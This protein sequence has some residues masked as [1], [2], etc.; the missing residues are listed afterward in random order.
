M[1]P[2]LSAFIFVLFLG[3]VVI[4]WR[5]PSVYA[6]QSV[7]TKVMR[8]ADKAQMLEV[9][10][11]GATD[12]Y[13]T[14]TFGPDNYDFDQTA[15][16]NPVLIDA[17]GN[18][19]DL[20]TFTPVSAQTGWGNL[21]VNQDH[22]GRK[23]RIAGETFE[24]GFFAHAP[25]ILHFRL[26]G[27]FDGESA[28]K[29]V[30]FRV[31]VG[32]LESAARGSSVFRVTSEPTKMPTSAEFKK[33]FQKPTPKFIVPPSSESKFEFNQE[34]AQ[35]LLDRGITELVFIRRL[36]LNSNHVYTDHV[37]SRWMPGGGLAVLD[38]RTGKVRDL[39]PELASGV[40]HRFDV[41]WDAKK[42]V[43]DF[44][45]D[46]LEG[47]RIYEI[48][49]DGT[50]L[51][52]LTFPPE[53]EQELITKYG[54]GGYHHGTDDMQPCYLPDGGIAFI[55][56]RC[57][58][59]VLCD[60]SDNFTV[61]NL[62]RMDADGGNMQPLTFSALSEQSPTVM[63][64]GRILY[65]RWEYL[66][67]AA[68]NVKALWAMNPDGTN[69]SEIYGNTI[70]FPE[71][72]IYA[73]QIPGAPDKIVF[74]GA[75]HCCPNNAVGTVI[76]LDTRKHIRAHEAM[77]YL[78]REVASFHHNGFHFLNEEGK[79]VHDMSGVPG[80]LFKD[81]Y[82]LS[83][84]LFLAARKPKGLPWNDVRGYD[85][86]LLDGEG[87]DTQL[88]KD[89][90]VSCWHPFPLIA[91]PI[92]PVRSSVREMTEN[93][94]N[95][96]AEKHAVAVITDIY[97]GMDDVPR[98]EVKYLRVLEQ[99]P[100][101]WSA[102]KPWYGKDHRGTTHAHSAIG[103]GHLSVKVQLGVIPV[104]EDGSAKFYVPAD[105]AVYFQALD[106]KY[107]AIQTERTYVNY[108]P[109]ETR[110]CVGC[111]ETPN[112]TP[113]RS[114][115]PLPTAMKLPVATLGHQPNQTEAE[116]V[117]DYDR[118]IQP[119]WDK[120]CIS[121]HGAEKQDGNL[122]LRGTPELT[123]CVSYHQLVRLS[124]DAKKQLLGNRAERNEDAAS[125]EIAYIPPYRTGALSST[126][127]GWL[128]GDGGALTAKEHIEY[129]EFLKKSHPNVK[130]S[131]TELLTINNWLDVNCP[132]HPSYF[133]H[134]NA[135]FA[136]YPNY[137]PVV[138][139]AEARQRNHNSVMVE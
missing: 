54:H 77:T 74:L 92:P 25:S 65:H 105:R 33:N 4:G 49:V 13:L 29:Y 122:D 26:S 42:I 62:Y 52:Q 56:T 45:P 82:P 83:E 71:C 137:R 46:A 84:T 129:V 134:L 130:L 30:K 57:E 86:V 70:A 114:F 43:F 113:T 37:N 106:E 111:H 85:L 87:N 14:A 128:S 3:L 88:L 121:C 2:T 91:R 38:L 44:K 96:E 127:S 11:D 22:V 8:V 51:R 79:W 59:S 120:H 16:C 24:R 95:K 136:D 109:G 125:N 39:A 126:L 101:S 53:N 7:E 55:S 81:P 97:V 69:S 123:Y 12:L 76:I 75:S 108:R 90:N 73:R 139:P 124:R 103:D 34:A 28:K 72:K 64:D 118:Q 135:E 99:I 21:V 41:S 89:V 100:R 6:F 10:L 23:F 61:T 35:K 18:E 138:T 117:F 116:M 110:A 48:N 93:T 131:E 15:W 112:D 66:D 63:A 67:K 40:V 17:D 78:T 132:Y 32:L 47:Y 80:R 104:A 60:A 119:I 133:G 20:T 98:G 50:G 36:T 5:I 27:K 58:I 115:G 31:H 102:R 94:E 1:K 68:G 107:R 19:T 9:N